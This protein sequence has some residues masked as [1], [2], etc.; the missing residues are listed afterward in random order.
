MNASVIAC[1][2]E[3][4]NEARQGQV[5]RVKIAEKEREGL[6]GEKLAAEAYLHKD[7]ERLGTQ[8]KIFQRFMHDGQVRHACQSGAGCSTQGMRL[9]QPWSCEAHSIII[10]KTTPDACQYSKFITVSAMSWVTW[11]VIKW[12]A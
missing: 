4:L 9:P 7:A 2:L 8:S 5:N 1:R 12:L 10:E 11:N 3:A 6:E